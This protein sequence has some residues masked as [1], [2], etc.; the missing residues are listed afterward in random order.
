MNPVGIER[1][2]EHNRRGAA[3]L[4]VANEHLAYVSPVEKMLRLTETEP[5]VTRYLIQAPQTGDTPKRPVGFFMINTVAAQIWAF[6]DPRTDCVLEGFLI[7]R[8]E[9]RRGYALAALHQIPALVREKNP[10]HSR[11]VLTV[12]CSNAPAIELYEKSGFEDTG[13]L[14]RGGR[15]GPQHV[16]ARRL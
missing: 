9:Q 13:E 15:S 12:N 10:E 3:G 11:L 4:Q 5:G 2:G 7:D 1:V 16:F 6:A 14:Y 8:R